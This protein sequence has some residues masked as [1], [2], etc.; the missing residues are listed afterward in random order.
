LNTPAQPVDL[1]WARWMSALPGERTLNQLTLPG[2]HDTCA[3]T[4]DDALA[5]TQGATLAE[6]LVHGVRVLDIR[7]RHEDDVFHINHARIALGLMFDDVIADCAG[8]LAQHPGECIV[9]SVKDECGTRACTRSFAQ[10]FETYV[11]RYPEVRWHLA[12]TTPRLADV[13]GA[14]VLLR[15]FESAAPLGIDLTAWPDNSTFDLDVEGAAFAIQDEFR[16]PVRASMEYKWRGIEALLARTPHVSDTRWVVNFCSGTG[17]AANPYVVACGDKDVRGMNDRFAGR[18]DGQ[19]DQQDG[20]QSGPAGTVMID[21]CEH[22]GWALV[23]ALV[24]R[25]PL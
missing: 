15:R 19:S 22:A 14:I 1:A 3:Y 7:C 10:T 17:M 8:F 5:R 21:F 11:Q 4:V 20:G 25:N 2:S 23:R 6:Q 16:V 9:M 24:A 12:N 18:I 13:R